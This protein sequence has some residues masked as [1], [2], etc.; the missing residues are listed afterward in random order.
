M[1]DDDD[2]DEDNGDDDYAEY[3]LNKTAF[4]MFSI[5]N[6]NECENENCEFSS[7]FSPLTDIDFRT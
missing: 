6:V 1:S 3:G 7:F 4:A 5:Y 2:T